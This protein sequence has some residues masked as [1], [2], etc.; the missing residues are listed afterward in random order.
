MDSSGGITWALSIVF[1]VITARL[2]LFRFFLKQVQ[3]QRHMQ[4][5]APQIAKLKEKHKGDR[6]KLQ[7]EMMKLQQEQGLNV[8]A[9]CL[10]MFLQIPVFLAL[11]HVLRHLSNSAGNT[12]VTGHQLNLYGFSAKETLSAAGA[13]LFGSAPLAASFHDSSQAITT[14][15]G[16]TGTTRIVALILTVI[17]A[18]ATYLTQ[19]QVQKNATTVPTGQAAQIQKIMLYVIPLFVLGSGYIFPIGVLLYWFTSNV[20]TMC[21]QF[22]IFKFHPHKPVEKSAALVEDSRPSRAPAP[23]AKPVRNRAS[24][25]PADSEVPVDDPS[26]APVRTNKPRP[27]SKPVGNRPGNKRSGQRSKRR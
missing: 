5:L 11:F 9:G 15:G 18:G 3:Y 22:Y 13:K 10:P 12:D 19:R 1:L 24:A 7:Q 2:L 14:L 6:Q 4:E 27:G 25:V 8:L 26:P 20:W 23:G 16:Q 17:S 21:Q